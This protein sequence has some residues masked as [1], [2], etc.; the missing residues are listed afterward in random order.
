MVSL[1]SNRTVTK[2]EDGISVT[3]LAMLLLAE[4][5]LWDSGLEKQLNILSKA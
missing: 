3:G 1:H 4:D 2:T 5:V